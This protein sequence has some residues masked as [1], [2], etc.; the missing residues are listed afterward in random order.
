MAVPMSFHPIPALGRFCKSATQILLAYSIHMS[1]GST[2]RSGRKND[3]EGK[4][5]CRYK[6]GNGTEVAAAPFPCLVYSLPVSAIFSTGDWI[7]L[8]SS[9]LHL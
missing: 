6:Q 5:R 1:I 2:S 3:Q 7:P 8:W 9:Y 4:W